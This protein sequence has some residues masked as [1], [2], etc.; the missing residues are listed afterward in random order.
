MTIHPHD[1]L[2]ADSRISY[3]LWY[4]DGRRPI[5]RPTLAASLDA[6][7]FSS[8]VMSAY[9]E[10]LGAAELQRFQTAVRKAFPRLRFNLYPW[11]LK[12]YSDNVL[13]ASPIVMDGEINWLNV[14]TAVAKFQASMVFSGYFVRGGLARGPIHLS[15]R[16]AYGAALIEAQEAE[17]HDADWPRVVL[18]TEAVVTLCDYMAYN[19]GVD[20]DMHGI[21]LLAGPRTNGG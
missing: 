21:Q 16:I 2:Y 5:E 19:N 20:P 8:M 14:T 9:K 1:L 7:G 4:F 15:S 18:T 3:R 11:F 13:L 10:D 6:L 12:T 17:A